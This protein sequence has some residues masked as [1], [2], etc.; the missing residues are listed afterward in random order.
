MALDAA[1]RVAILSTWLR[2]M[3]DP[4]VRAESASLTVQ[5]PA[6]AAVAPTRQDAVN[7]DA[8]TKGGS[9]VRPGGSS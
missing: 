6:F 8:Q 1:A 3:L 4:Y 5:L 7:L 2:S 9:K